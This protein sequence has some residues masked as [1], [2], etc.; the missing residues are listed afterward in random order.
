MNRAKKGDTP[1]NWVV[2][3]YGGSSVSSRA[4][5]QRI[6]EHA[7]AC[8]AEGLRPL[9]VQSALKGV[10]NQLQALLDAA[11]QEDCAAGLLAI[12]DQ[13]ARLAAEMQI[14][15]PEGIDALL[16]KTGK[17]LAGVRLVGEVSPR[18]AARVLCIGELMASLVSA[19]YLQAQ[20]KIDCEWLDAREILHSLSGA[21]G[22]AHAEYLAA[23]CAK[24]PDKSLSRHLAGKNKIILTQGFIASN[25]K[26]ETV[27]LGRG[28]SDTS[29]ACM[30]AL[31]GARRL[32]IWSDVPG[33]FTADPN[34]VPSARL[35][36]RLEYSEAQ[37]ISSMGGKVLHP[38]CITPL[39]EYGIPLHLGCTEH[40]EIE[41]TIVSAARDASPRVKAVSSKK[42]VTLVSMQTVG[43]WHHVGFLAEAFACFR[44]Q[45]ISV[46]LVSTSETNVTV[47]LDPADGRM[48][49]EA[50]ERL[51]RDL[52][53]ICKV[54]LINDCAAV[55]L[56]GRNIR[57]ILHRLGPVL[58]LFEEH[59]IH[60]VT[61][62]ANDLNFSVVVDEDQAD[63]LV[64]KLHAIVI[65]A[66]EGDD[67]LGPTWQQVFQQRSQTP[68]ADSWWRRKRERLLA[69]APVQGSAYVYDLESIDAAC[70]RLAEMTAVS[71]RLYAV[72][73]NW[74]PDV[75]ARM[76]AAGMGFEC[77]SEGEVRH[78]QSIF[79]KMSPDRILF[80]PNFAPR[81]EY[82][83]GFEA[84]VNLTLDSLSPLESWPELF[85]G[86][87][88]FVR[89]D[90]GK[91][92]G[93]HQHVRT[94]GVHS[95]FGVPLFEL[96]RLRELAASAGVII[97]GLHSHAGSGVMSAEHWPAMAE[98][99]A[100]IADLIGTVRVLDLG[101][102]LGVPE[103]PGAEG[104]DLAD[105]NARLSR[106]REDRPEYQLWLEP[107][108]Y[109]VAGAGV[110]LAR[111]TQVKGKGMTRYVGLN[112][113]M[114]SLI[115][116]MLYG[117]WHEIV[118]LT[119]LADDATGF[120]TVVGP[121][122]ESG[123]TLG[124]ERLLPRCE[125]DDVML[126][127]NVGA[128]GRVMSSRYNLREPAAEVVIE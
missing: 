56:I 50:L 75:L 111:V 24:E 103:K 34:A 43:M 62:A 42:G 67:F 92:R 121:I 7:R 81:S 122:C 76:H 63:R 27:V 100:A 2:L 45:G 127:A 23:D 128:Y 70:A 64:Q 47:S 46:D 109:L 94:A 72:K 5:W 36:R 69:M 126:I 116:P 31:L 28:G 87:N 112:T 55:S 26:G 86:R 99:M 104:L 110:L 17:V 39:K 58:E 40:P 120:A 79:P 22:D 95:K 124:R 49:S 106:V 68:A 105:L 53:R 20:E 107:G 54:S 83:F 16:E 25:D 125:V 89:L 18:V 32:E 52:G 33:M 51:S 6:A 60:L 48:R 44:R 101:G 65:A 3:K 84:G 71:R 115:R 91:G 102:G 1:D 96:E 118:N 14:E 85:R 38:R 108:R 97:V 57:A 90:M 15:L 114:N 4:A 10:T 11:L 73:A 82:A 13:H 21:D 80:T 77:V 9:I 88:V 35:L 19:R 12:R 66:N 59:R 29:A 98:E 113:G 8:V 74:Q 123:D 93:H 37:E 117:A 30:A 61:Q 41:G 78:V 119:R